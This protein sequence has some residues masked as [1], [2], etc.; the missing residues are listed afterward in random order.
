MI[1]FPS[2]NKACHLQDETGIP[3][4][5]MTLDSLDLISPQLLLRLFY[6]PAAGNLSLFPGWTSSFHVSL[7]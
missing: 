4:W 1:G 7:S 6:L 3:N 5:I 2:K